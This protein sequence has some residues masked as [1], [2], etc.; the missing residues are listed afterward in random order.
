MH[1]SVHDGVTI[2]MFP[3][4]SD[5]YGFLVHDP[6]SGETAAIDTPDADVI[7][8]AADDRGWKITHIWNTHWHM[9]HAGGNA[10]IKD[11]TGAKILAPVEVSERLGAP[12]DQIVQGGDVVMLGSIPVDVIDT[13]GHTLGH[14]TYFI[15]DA[16]VAFVGDTLFALGCGRMFEGKP[17]QFTD[18]LAR[19]VALPEETRIFCAHEYTLANLDFALDVDPHNKALRIRETEIRQLRSLGKPTVPTVLGLER[20]TNPFLRAWDADMQAQLGVPG[21]VVA[22]FAGLRTAKDQF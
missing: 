17:E 5:N 10:A 3:C 15:Q 19:L 1:V 8:Q 9:D 13:G 12:V 22:A 7:L 16:N 4:L 2:S 18:S 6:A 20:K 14:V 21:N 11:A